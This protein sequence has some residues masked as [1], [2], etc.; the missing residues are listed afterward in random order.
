MGG[1]RMPA[2]TLNGRGGR[3]RHGWRAWR[4]P[5]PS[6]LMAGLC[7][8]GPAALLWL[9]VLLVGPGSVSRLAPPCLFH[10]AT[11]WHCAGC[12]GTRCAMALCRGDW[13]AALDYH[14]VAAFALPVALLWAVGETLAGLTGWRIPR[15]RLSW[16]WWT[17]GLVSLVLF[18]VLR[19][20]PFGWTA[21][22]GP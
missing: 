16:R 17:V 4:S 7:V 14:P 6:R 8:L 13:S 3:L 18:G 22:M 1:I 11:G 12:G 9:G 19:N 21:W 20:L 10:L 2:A 15:W 5:A